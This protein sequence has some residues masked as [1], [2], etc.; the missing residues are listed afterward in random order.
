VE[1]NGTTQI[2]GSYSRTTTFDDDSIDG[3]S[4]F[5]NHLGK[6]LFAELLYGDYITLQ[7][8][9]SNDAAVVAANMTFGIYKLAG[10]G[11]K[12]D[13]GDQGDPGSGSTVTV[14][15]EGTNVPNTPHSTINFKG[16]AVVAADAG[17]G[18]V[19]VTVSG[20]SESA[21]EKWC[22][23][24]KLAKLRPTLLHKAT[25]NF[26]PSGYDVYPI[27]GHNW[28]AG[29]VSEYDHG[30]NYPYTIVVKSGTA[31]NMETDG[32]LF[33]IRSDEAHS[34]SDPV[35]NDDP[36][37][38]YFKRIQY[39]QNNDYQFISAYVSDNGWDTQTISPGTYDS[40]LIGYSFE[41][42]REF[43]VINNAASRHLYHGNL[44]TDG[45]FADGFARHEDEFFIP[46]DETLK[47]DVRAGDKP[48]GGGIYTVRYI[49]VPSWW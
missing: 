2:N 4:A 18:V 42:I 40:L 48:D 22:W 9:Y 31:V 26:T 24:I 20:A 27:V 36:K 6:A 15:D 47:F 12:G 19:D 21:E 46:F 34:A 49:D 32:W 25:S 5:K 28:R 38:E 29:T 14:Q 10:A 11:P 13:K 45:Y 1:K 23:Q 17:S 43:N 16:D 39:I 37:K 33:Y 7:L 41:N 8:M 35:Q 30:A 3:N 44:Q